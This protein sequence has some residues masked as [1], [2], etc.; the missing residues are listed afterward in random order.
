LGSE[1][2]GRM[3]TNEGVTYPG[4]DELSFFL[5]HAQRHRRRWLKILEVAE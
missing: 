5:T 1:E 2:L 3:R 4:V